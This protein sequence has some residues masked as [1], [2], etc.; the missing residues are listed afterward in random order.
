MTI[1][2][3]TLAKDNILHVGKKMLIFGGGDGR[4]ANNITTLIDMTTFAAM[5]V[6]V[7]GTP[8]QERV[9]HA[10]SL[11]GGA[12]RE[13][14][15]VFG[16]ASRRGQSVAVFVG[17]QLPTTGARG[18]LRRRA[19]LT[20]F[21]HPGFVRKLGYMFDVHVLDIATVQWQQL[22]VRDPPSLALARL[23]PPSRA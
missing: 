14:L 12:G 15:Y 11:V 18:C 7:R 2:P 9:G 1:H 22:P 3:G 8:P 6:G 17:P 4:V 21:G 19:F 16:G 10:A 20:A 23:P 5:P 13:R